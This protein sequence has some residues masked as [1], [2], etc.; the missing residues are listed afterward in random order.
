MILDSPVDGHDA[1]C[2][3][4]SYV[5]V[6]FVAPGGERRQM[7][8]LRAAHE[9]RLEDCVPVRM[10]PVRRGKRLAPGW[11]WSATTGRLVHYGSAAQRDRLM[12]LDQDRQVVDLACRPVE[13]VWRAGSS[14]VRHAPQLLVRWAGGRRELV[15]CVG[16]SG[17]SRQLASRVRVLGSCARAAGWG[18]RLVGP[19]D[20][21]RVANV[22]WLSGYR[23]P[24]YADAAVVDR[25]REAC[26]VPRPAAEAV[27]EVGEAIRVWPALFHA[28]W[29]SRLHVD[30]DQVLGER[31]LITA[32]AGAA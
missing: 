7:P 20:P 29:S 25:L 17:P 21:V 30:L 23:H 3:D 10:F 22:R 12:L 2:P 19:A 5:D 27:C 4:P 13:F 6:R 31:S 11:W 9:Q 15:D 18:Y 28:L 24:R 16:V 8:W 1:A 14:V 32:G 26:V